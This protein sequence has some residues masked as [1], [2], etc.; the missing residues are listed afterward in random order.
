MG[1]VDWVYLTGNVL[2][3]SFYEYRNETTVYING[4]EFLD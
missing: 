2:L 3:V 1:S 4:G